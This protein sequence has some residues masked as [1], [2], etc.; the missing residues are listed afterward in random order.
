M[1]T[2]S[3]II[4]SYNR[5][6]YLAECLAS[7]FAQSH[8]PAQVIV[9]DDGSTDGTMD[10]LAQDTRGVTVIRQDNAGPGAARNRGAQVAT[11][12]YLAFLDSDDLWF[13]W[14]LE[15]Y[16]KLIAGVANPSLLF[17]R[18]VDFTTVDELDGI[19]GSPPRGS[20]YPDFLSSSANGYFCGAGM[21]VISRAA[22]AG[23]DGFEQDFL[24]AEDHDL[25]LQLGEAPGFINVVEPVT[26]AHRVHD[27][28]EMSDLAK[29][30]KGLERLVRK[31]KAAV[32]PGGPS[33][34]SARRTIISRHIRPAVMSALQTSRGTEARP[35]FKATLGW[36]ARQGRW[37]FLGAT[38]F[39]A[40]LD[41][42]THGRGQ[43]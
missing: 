7:V 9:V 26:V 20:F 29:T 3:V 42:V 8:P 10:M 23:S 39:Y 34:R 1:H 31:E 4:P 12:D 41:F 35:L 24:N 38:G 11:G 13:P 15:A 16:A 2:F 43:S 40:L 30:L 22:F 25:A 17:G 37:R 28:N 21:M 18:Y 14:T 27:G 6:R 33:R 36:H 32:Y 19:T 5:K